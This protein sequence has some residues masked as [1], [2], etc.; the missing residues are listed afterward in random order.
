MNS[1]FHPKFFGL[2]VRRDGSQ[3]S[4]FVRSFSPITKEATHLKHFPEFTDL[5]QE[6]DRTLL[7]FAQTPSEI[8]VL[9]ARYCEK[10][11]KAGK[12]A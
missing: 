6:V 4:I 9:M 8:T 5:Q 11:G 2:N 12:A 3:P 1:K 10:L 7:H